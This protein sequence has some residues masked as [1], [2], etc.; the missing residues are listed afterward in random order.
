[1]DL[2]E[3]QALNAAAADSTPRSDKTDQ[4]QNDA[5]EDDFDELTEA[6][7]AEIEKRAVGG[8]V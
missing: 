8:E 5:P 3:A 4:H 7:L 2:L 1:L 6:E